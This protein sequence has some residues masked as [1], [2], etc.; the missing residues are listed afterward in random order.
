MTIYL[1]TNKCLENY[2][3]L[4]RSKYFVDKSSIIEKI[5]ELIGTT[6]RYLC[7]TRPRRFGKSSVVDM[8]GAYYSKAVYSKDIFD[9]WDY[10]F[11]N[12]LFTENQD[13]Y[14]GFLSYNEGYL[15]IPNK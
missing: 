5:N 13:D 11:N 1:N 12:N 14:L 10:I 6:D 2:K 15:K 4:N 7:I 8:L 9:E 3:I